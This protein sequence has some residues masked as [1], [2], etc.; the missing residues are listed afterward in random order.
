M[1]PFANISKFVLVQS[2]K[3]FR[4]SGILPE[5]TDQWRYRKLVQSFDIVGREVNAPENGLQHN[6]NQFRQSATESFVINR[7]RALLVW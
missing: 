3:L 5:T 6:D 7:R 1:K 2:L 4:S